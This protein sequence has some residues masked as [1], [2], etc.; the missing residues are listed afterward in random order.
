MVFLVRNMWGFLST[1]HSTTTDNQNLANKPYFYLVLLSTPADILRPVDNRS[2]ILGLVDPFSPS[3]D[4]I[5][6]STL[7]YCWE[8]LTFGKSDVFR[9][10]LE[11]GH[12][13]NSETDTPLLIVLSC[14]CFTGWYDVI[15][16]LLFSGETLGTWVGVSLGY[17]SRS[18]VN[19]VSMRSIFSGAP[20]F[21]A[22]LHKICLIW[23]ALWLTS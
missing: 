17:S 11:T 7:G 3:W 5:P 9:N 10:P 22:V 13:V 15:I 1:S 8:K 4:G 2:V 19:Q 12:L 18:E 20:I 21:W 23:G 14:N 6:L 16:F